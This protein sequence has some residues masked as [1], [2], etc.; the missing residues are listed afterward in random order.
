MQQN[1]LDAPSRGEEIRARIQEKGF[2]RRFYSEIYEKYKEVLATCP[3]EGI[4]LELGSGGGFAKGV[5]P[6]LVSSDL[7]GYPGIDRVVD[8]TK[9][10]FESNSLRALFMMNVFHHIP[11]V[12]AFLH[13]AERCLM[14]GAKIYICDQ[15]LGL[16]SSFILKYFHHEP[17][18]P[19]RPEWTFE[20]KGPLSD[21]NG[22]LA[23]I[24]FQRD[25]E[26]Y[27]KLFPKLR[28]QKYL[29]HSPLR[30]WLS[31]GMRNWSFLPESAFSLATF[32]D[33]ALIHI[34]PQ[35]G[36]FVDIEIEK[37]P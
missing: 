13:E 16:I 5:I 8:A 6:D 25:L 15:H 1:H 19:K 4:I 11:D 35:F 36:S 10:P 14:P 29:P 3:K 9:M 17:F 22:A 31:G 12:K 37:L 32:I 33:Q 18:D 27:K 2:L 24:V 28:L 26:K 23:W 21:A 20:S 7:I 34:S 30:Y